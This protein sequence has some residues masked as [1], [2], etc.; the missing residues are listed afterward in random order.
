MIGPGSDKKSNTK[1]FK[2]ELDQTEILVK[3]NLNAKHAREEHKKL[4]ISRNIPKE[5]YPL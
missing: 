3:L 2:K 4:E 1:F 5:K